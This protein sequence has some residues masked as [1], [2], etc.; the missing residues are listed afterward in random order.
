MK[1]IFI[2]FQAPQLFE[3]LNRKNITT[4]P[5]RASMSAFTNPVSKSVR[6]YQFRIWFIFFSSTGENLKFIF[7][8]VGS[9]LKIGQNLFVAWKAQEINISKNW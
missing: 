7:F 3:K 8:A 6:G 2:Y 9:I 5:G 4:A 1:G